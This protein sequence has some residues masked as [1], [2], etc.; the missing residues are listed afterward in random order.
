MAGAARILAVAEAVAEVGEARATR[1]KL[2]NAADVAASG[3]GD[4]GVAGA[5]G[6]AALGVG[7]AE[8]VAGAGGLTALPVSDVVEGDGVVAEAVVG[9]DGLAA[10]DGVV[11]EAVVGVDG[12]AAL[13]VAAPAGAT[14]EPVLEAAVLVVTAVAADVEPMPLVVVELAA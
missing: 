2:I 11:A 7:V 6:L 3:A 9:V 12:L 8:V 10:L 1:S 4:R 5:V 13:G 14:T